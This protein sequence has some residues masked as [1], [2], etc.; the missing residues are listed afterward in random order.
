LK[1]L[2]NVQSLLPPRTGIGF[3]TQ[4]LIAALAAT[5]ELEAVAVSWG[6]HLSR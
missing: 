4:H 5:G 2:F 1:V 6:A 3:Y